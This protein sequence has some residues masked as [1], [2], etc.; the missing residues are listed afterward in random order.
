VDCNSFR[1]KK[2]RSAYEK[3]VQIGNTTA[4]HMYI[5]QRDTKWWEKIY[6]MVSEDWSGRANLPK[7]LYV[8]DTER[9]RWRANEKRLNR[10]TNGKRRASTCINDR[11]PCGGHCMVTRDLGTPYIVEPSYYIALRYLRYSISKFPTELALI[12][13]RLQGLNHSWAWN[14]MKRFE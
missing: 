13:C 12:Y 7:W 3:H 2:K 11:P 5:V 6:Q 4:T 14:E 8:L 9:W 1:G 10:R